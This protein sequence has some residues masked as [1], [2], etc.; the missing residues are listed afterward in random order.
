LS[1]PESKQALNDFYNNFYSPRIMN[2]AVCSPMDINE[3]EKLVT[4]KF[5]AVKDKKVT[6]PDISDPAPYD[7][8]NSKRFVGMVPVHDLDEMTITWNLPYYGGAEDD[9]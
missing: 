5:K 8:N 4:K 7:T 2:L 1:K 6:L 3:L 9:E